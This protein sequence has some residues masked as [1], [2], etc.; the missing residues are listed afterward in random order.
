M[1]ISKIAIE[2]YKSFLKSEEIIFQPGINV[3]IGPN[4]SGKTALLEVLSG[5]FADRPHRSERN[6][7]HNLTNSSKQRSIAAYTIRIEPDELI[8]TLEMP[9]KPSIVPGP[10]VG[11]KKLA[12]KSF[13]QSLQVGLNLKLK[14]VSGNPQYRE[15]NY[16]WY[17]QPKLDHPHA[18][19]R[20]VPDYRNIPHANGET[21]VIPTG[22]FNAVEHIHHYP[23]IFEMSSM[24]MQLLM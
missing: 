22:K 5:K 14:N 16:G 18:F 7:P 12:A 13:N 20:L 9:H 17:D 2:N 21:E 19:V 1:H 23:N 15:M 11:D 24:Q 3:I 6:T 4:N 10:S 8:R